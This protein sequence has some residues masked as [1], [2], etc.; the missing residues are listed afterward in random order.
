MV[1]KQKKTDLYHKSRVKI[2]KYLLTAFKILVTKKRK[3]I[4]TC[5]DFQGTLINDELI[6]Q[7]FTGSLKWEN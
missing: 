3:K 7:M 4:I 5:I 1:K 6:K 2:T